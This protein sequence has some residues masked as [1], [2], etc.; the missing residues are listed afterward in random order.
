MAYATSQEPRYIYPDDDLLQSLVFVY[1]DKFNPFYPVL[2]QPTFRRL[3]DAREHIHNSDFGMTVLLVCALASIYSNDPRV[4][5]PGDTSN[6]SAGW[7]FF[8]QVPLHRNK[9]IYKSGLYDL[10][11]FAVSEISKN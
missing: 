4:M 7:R 2:H 10:Q 9:L 5:M 6:L 11:Y 1:F 3:L 8:S